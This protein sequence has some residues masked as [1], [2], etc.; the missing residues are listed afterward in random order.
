M[1]VTT[2]VTSYWSRFGRK[3]Q[4]LLVLRGKQPRFYDAP[5]G[6]SLSVALPTQSLRACQ[7]P[8][9]VA[10]KFPTAGAS[11]PFRFGGTTGARLCSWLCQSTQIRC[12]LTRRS[13]GPSAAVGLGPVSGTLYIFAARA[14]P[15]YRGGPFSSTL[16]ITGATLRYS[17]RVS[18]LRRELKQPQRG[19]AA[20]TSRR[21]RETANT[22]RGLRVVP[23]DCHHRSGFALVALRPPKRR[24]SSASRSAAAA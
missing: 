7:P 6:V 18:A 20:S 2:A 13:N 21:L 19:N 12:C 5:L 4:E 15:A 3:S 24:A 8:V 11:R 16:G 10:L 22:E 9:Q 14:K 23:N 17:T 1:T